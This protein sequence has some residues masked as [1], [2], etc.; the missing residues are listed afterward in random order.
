VQKGEGTVMKI[1][2]RV[3][4][5]ESSV[6]KDFTKRTN[7][8]Q[9]VNGKDPVPLIIAAIG[10]SFAAQVLANIIES[11]AEGV[12][13]PATAAIDLTTRMATL[14]LHADEVTSKLLEGVLASVFIDEAGDSSFV[15]IDNQAIKDVFRVV[16]EATVLAS[17][18]VSE[19]A[20]EIAMESIQEAFSNAV[21]YGLGGAVATWAA[22]RA[23]YAPPNDFLQQPAVDMLDPI[24][25]ANLDAMVGQNV[26]VTT[27]MHALRLLGRTLEYWTRADKID[28]LHRLYAAAGNVPLHMLANATRVLDT[29]I[30]YMVEQIRAMLAVIMRRAIDIVDEVNAAYADYLVQMIDETQF[31]VALESGRVELKHLEQMIED[32]L[33]MIDAMVDQLSDADTATLVNI[34]TVIDMLENS[35]ESFAFDDYE[36]M[37]DYLTTLRYARRRL[38]STGLTWEFISPKTGRRKSFTL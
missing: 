33:N 30:D 24:T 14:G 5:S 29:A 1:H 21:Y 8:R 12:T 18:L 20:G 7:R 3:N 15:N 25:I 9:I 6:P 26:Y 36:E 37:R 11:A 4:I 23:G 22:Y 28:E 32:T 27:A 16:A 34:A 2:R 35:L 17:T 19:D 38:K 13:R 10:V 31:R